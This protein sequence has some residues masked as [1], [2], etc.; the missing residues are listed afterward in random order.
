MTV[1]SRPSSGPVGD[2]AETSAGPDKIVLE[3][4]S[5]EGPLVVFHGSRGGTERRPFETWCAPQNGLVS[6]RSLEGLHRTSPAPEADV[7]SPIIGPGTDH[8]MT[9]SS[10]RGLDGLIQVRASP[11]QAHQET[12]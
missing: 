5:P 1:Q 3:R 7:E 8:N 2:L 6:S 10:E 4:R 11:L 9:F 12:Q